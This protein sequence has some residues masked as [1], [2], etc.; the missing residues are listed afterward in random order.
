MYSIV[1]FNKK[2]TKENPIMPKEFVTTPDKLNSV[3]SDFVTSDQY[4]IVSHIPQYV[5]GIS[6]VES[7]L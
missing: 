5:E 2:S 4:V 7:I 3:V 1:V 6:D